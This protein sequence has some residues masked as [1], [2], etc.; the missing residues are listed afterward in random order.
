MSE[1]GLIIGLLSSK[2]GCGKSTIAENLA[3]GFAQKNLKVAI[4]D[5]D[6]KQR[7]SSKWVARRNDAHPELPKIN[8]FIESENLIHSIK[9]HSEN[10]D[11][12]I[13]DVQGSDSRSLRAGFLV[14]DIVYVPFIPSQHDLETMEE[15]AIVI[16]E[17]RIQNPDCQVLALMNVCPPHALNASYSGARDYVADFERECGIKLSSVKIVSRIAYQNSAMQ[18]IG[19]LESN[20]DKAKHEIKK[21]IKEI[22]ENV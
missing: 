9:H 20:D 14:A 22:E 21:L 6:Y 1:R 11:V 18:G 10:N 19:V 12:C 5:C 13:I 2:G 4:I 3:V 17:A 8:C 15:T 7:T 16:D